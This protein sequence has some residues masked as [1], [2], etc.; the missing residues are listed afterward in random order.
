MLKLNKKITLSGV[1]GKVEFRF[2]LPACMSYDVISFENNVIDVDFLYKDQECVDAATVYLVILQKDCPKKEI[3]I[4]LED[5]CQD[6]EFTDVPI[7][8]ISGLKFRANVELSKNMPYSYTW[9][10]ETDALKVKSIQNNE[11]EFEVLK[12]ITNGPI[13]IHVKVKN[14]NGC[15]ISDTLNHDLCLPVA[16]SNYVR[17]SCEKGNIVAIHKIIVQTCDSGPGCAEINVV[18]W[19]TLKIDLPLRTTWEHLGDG[20]IKIH[21]PYDFPETQV[22]VNFCVKDILGI[23]ACGELCVDVHSC[24]TDKFYIRAGEANIGCQDCID[25]QLALVP[26]G[27]QV[28]KNAPVS[29]QIENLISSS[30]TPNWAS[31]EFIPSMGDTVVSPTE[32]VTPNGSWKFGL[33]HK[34]VFTPTVQAPIETGRFKILDQ[35]GRQANGYIDIFSEPVCLETGSAVV[36]FDDTVCV[37]AGATVEFSP[38]TNDNGTP[39]VT[40]IEVDF[41]PPEV[42]ELLIK[43]TGYLVFTA[44]PAFTGT[45]EL[46]YAVRDTDGVLSN[47]SSIFLNVMA[48]P[49]TPEVSHSVCKEQSFE[50]FPFS[51]IDTDVTTYLWRYESGKAKFGVNG[52]KRDYSFGE[53]I[54]NNHNPEL[55]FSTSPAGEY[56]FSYGENM[57]SCSNR[58]YIKIE[59]VETMNIGPNVSMD[60]CVNHG[61]I[62]LSSIKELTGGSWA[63][64]TPGNLDDNQFDPSVGAGTYLYRYTLPNEGDYGDVCD[65]VFEVSFNVVEEVNAGQP[66]CIK[67]CSVYPTEIGPEGCFNPDMLVYSPSCGICLFSVLLSDGDKTTGGKWKLVTAPKA[68]GNI[69]WIGSELKFINVGGYVP[70]DYEGC[71]DLGASLPGDYVFI[72]EV[73]VKDTECYA[74]Q[75]VTVQVL[76]APELVDN[77]E[78]TICD[79]HGEEY[80]WHMM[81]KHWQKEGLPKLKLCSGDFNLITGD[82][83]IFVLDGCESKINTK[84]K[85]FTEDETFVLT[86]TYG[87]D[88]DNDCEDDACDD[89]QTCYKAIQ[90]TINVDKDDAAGT[91]NNFTVC[92]GACIVNLSDRLVNAVGGGK[93]SYVG[94]NLA[95]SSAIDDDCDSEI[96]GFSIGDKLG[97]NIIAPEGEPG[98]YWFEYKVQRGRCCST[99]RV[100][101]QVVETEYAGEDGACTLCQSNSC[102]ALYDLI[103]GTPTPGGV[104]INL[105]GAQEALN[106]CTGNGTPNTC[107]GEE[108]ATGD[109]GFHEAT[110]T[111]NSTGLLGIFKFLYIVPVQSPEFEFVYST[112]DCCKAVLINLE[113]QEVQGVTLSDSEFGNGEGAIKQLYDILSSPVPGGTWYYLGEGDG[114]APDGSP[115]KNILVGA[116]TYAPNSQLGTSDHVAV[117]FEGQSED[118]YWFRYVVGTGECSVSDDAYIEISN[119]E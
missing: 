14:K 54:G 117:N 44:N 80:L 111:F 86:F 52:V 109:V 41:P 4:T 40:S 99:T 1:T 119:G 20:F 78:L 115:V 21:F 71:I 37:N 77:I 79:S 75:Q 105:S 53:Q 74:E 62:Q 90:L 25:E 16:E 47:V 112:G 3:E 94:C 51:L 89:C 15:C 50:L 114:L 66:N 100:I 26:E 63:N 5:P 18:D 6:L 108:V 104:W 82:P 23:E 67:V 68:V 110:G 19:G 29:V 11:V 39:D 81:L 45:H 69:I 12:H 72:Y 9:D 42:G 34:V 24:T 118:H 30:T 27:N 73:G 76:P 65:S 101:M 83:N 13:N 97:G 32:I 36:T 57:G 88:V 35:D 64:V 84:N 95:S 87:I 7:E 33:D 10:A 106:T 56:I 22:N 93:W 116:T 60:V 2:D 61:I 102:I 38:L 107:E 43:N 17:S 70:G 113:V 8:H 59:I 58:I 103:E 98:F 49:E 31:F 96:G 46:S 48:T 28:C 91:A 85:I 92:E 55:D